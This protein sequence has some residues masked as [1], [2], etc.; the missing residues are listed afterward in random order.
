[1]QYQVLTD[2]LPAFMNQHRRDWAELEPVWKE[3]R[4]GTEPVLA[5]PDTLVWLATGRQ[6]V[7]LLVPTLNWYR[8]DWETRRR[9]F[10]D[11]AGYARTQGLRWFLLRD[12]DF[13]RDMETGMHERLIGELKADGRWERVRSWGT[14]GLYRL[15]ER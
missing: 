11:A 5:D 13:S 2:V 9:A 4:Q 15:K 10:A 14:V 8:E 1:M 12:K 6:S 7:S 3:L